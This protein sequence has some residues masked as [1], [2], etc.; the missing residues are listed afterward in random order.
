MIEVKGNLWT[1]P[2]DA[3]V[4]T[5]NGT[6]KKNGEAVMGRGCAQEAK[7]KLLE[8]YDYR[9]NVARMVGSVIQEIGNHV[10]CLMRAPRIFTFPVK[11][12]WFENADP[13]LIVRSAQELVAIED[14][15]RD[16]GNGDKVIVMPR[17]GCGNGHLKWHEHIKELLEP[18]LD[19]RFHIISFERER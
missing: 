13:A 15:C 10:F 2:A 6:I 4:I 12:N 8:L 14:E 1:Y 16:K 3:R 17:P 11:H 18:I 9:P 19:D 5:T 7:T